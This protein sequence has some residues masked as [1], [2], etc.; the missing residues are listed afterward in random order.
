MGQLMQEVR[1]VYCGAKDK[2]SHLL[3]VILGSDTTATAAS[4][5]QS[6]G[7]KQDTGDGR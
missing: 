2:V 4:V 1:Q 3:L 6:N 5:T 7:G